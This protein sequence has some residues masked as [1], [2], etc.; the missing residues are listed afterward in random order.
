M[1]DSRR[2][3]ILAGVIALIV[4]IVGYVM[5]TRSAPP[6]PTIGPGQTLQNPFGSQGAK[7][8]KRAQ[9]SQQAGH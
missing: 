4:V 1:E 8:N 2:N 7:L 9:E 6:E 3:A 5:W